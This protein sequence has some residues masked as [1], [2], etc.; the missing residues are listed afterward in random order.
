MLD[1]SLIPDR[2]AAFLA[3]SVREVNTLAANPSEGPS[4]RSAS[5]FVC[6]FVGRKSEDGSAEIMGSTTDL[7]LRSIC[8][9]CL[10]VKQ[11]IS[12]QER[13]FVLMTDGTER[14]FNAYLVI[15][16]L[17]RPRDRLKVVH[18]Y[19]EDLQEKLIQDLQMPSI[20]VAVPF[21]PFPT[22]FP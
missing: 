3:W 22:T 14:C 15:Q 12:K 19:E 8:V 4:V 18:F 17:M 16:T 5:F 21:Q 10:I 13:T 9:P 7:A 6:G 20:K 11:A 1:L 2:T